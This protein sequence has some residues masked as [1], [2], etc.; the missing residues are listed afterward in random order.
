MTRKDAIKIFLRF[1]VIFGFCC[2]IFVAIGIALGDNA[3]GFWE[4][5][6]YVVIGGLIFILEEYF[7][8]KRWKNRMIARQTT[9]PDKYLAEQKKMLMQKRIGDKKAKQKN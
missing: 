3:N 2:P 6:I 5:A 8:W 1:I 9:N 7:Y 4:T